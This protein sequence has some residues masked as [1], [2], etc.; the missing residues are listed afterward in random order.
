[1]RLSQLPQS[2]SGQPVPT[3]EYIIQLM[4]DLFQLTVLESSACG[5]LAMCTSTEHHGCRCVPWRTAHITA[6]REHR[7]SRDVTRGNILQGPP[8]KDLLLPLRPHLPK[9][10]EAPK[11]VL[12]AGDRVKLSK[13]GP[14]GMLHILIIILNNKQTKTHAKYS[15]I[16]L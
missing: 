15:T 3:T 16:P 8:H 1:M 2:W 11:I 12:P 4:G 14:V 13:H 6:G 5:V 10:P 9:F 7:P